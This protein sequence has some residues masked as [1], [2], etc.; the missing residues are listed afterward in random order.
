MS[1]FIMVAFYG[2]R[3]LYL[4][5]LQERLHLQC[6][7]WVGLGTRI[8]VFIG[9]CRLPVIAVVYDTRCTS[10]GELRQ[11]RFPPPRPR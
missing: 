3:M 10:S 1:G 6:G 9:G 4:E 5:A 8:L 11:E 7:G 2:F